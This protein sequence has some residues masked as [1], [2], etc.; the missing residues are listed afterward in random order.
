MCS[1]SQVEVDKA[2]REVGS[3]W[4]TAQQ[5]DTGAM[6]SSL[7]LRK[8]GL[9][10]QGTQHYKPGDCLSERL[11]GPTAMLP[12]LPAAD[13]QV[14]TNWSPP[15]SY[16]QQKPQYCQPVLKYT[17]YVSRRYITRAHLSL[18][19]VTLGPVIRAVMKAFN[20]I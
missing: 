2:P 12:A 19:G 17:L 3:L 11:S 18:S 1:H 4:N 13:L 7:I 6:M 15:H 10:V 16:G 5:N 14:V 20:E 8:V 9:Q